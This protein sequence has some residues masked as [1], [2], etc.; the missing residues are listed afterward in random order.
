MAVLLEILLETAILAV[1]LG[2]G[3]AIMKA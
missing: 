3:K 1:F 2:I